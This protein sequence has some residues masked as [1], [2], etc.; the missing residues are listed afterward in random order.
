MPSAKEIKERISGVRETKQIT[1]AMYLVASTKL[2]HAREDL[3]KTRPYFDAL[4]SEIKKVFRAD[5][6]TVSRYFID[7]D[8]TLPDSG[9]CGILAITGDK[10][11]AGAYNM[12]VLRR[13]EA[14]RKEH[15]DARTFVIGEYGR[16][17]F[18]T[19]RI[20]YEEDFLYTAQAPSQD[21]SREICTRL[22]S[23]YETAQLNE[24]LVVYTDMRSSMSAEVQVQRLLPLDREQFSGDAEQAGEGR[25]E[26]FPSQEAV[27]AA[28]MRSYL[29]G[30][31][32]SATVDSL[33]SEQNA[34]VTAMEAANRNAEELLGD[35]ALQLNRERQS[36][37]TQEITEISAGAQAQRRSK[38]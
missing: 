25:F 1:S 7:E 14:L 13:V 9:V 18:H 30:F 17:Y 8:G 11:L 37:I 4:R 32:Y 22:L 16:R 29:S 3:E 38:G 33:C 20:P 10:G 21:I 28:V 34:R 15:P 19:H 26:F 6:H 2:R 12:N 24:L 36:A 27:V 5:D 35:L 31:I 23:L